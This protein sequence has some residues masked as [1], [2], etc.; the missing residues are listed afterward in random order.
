MEP[1]ELR[2]PER[3]A[4]EVTLGEVA[5]WVKTLNV[6]E[7]DETAAAAEVWAAGQVRAYREPDSAPALFLLDRF[8]GMF[9]EDQC[10]FLGEAFLLD[11][12]WA[13]DALRR[14]PG[15][16]AAA[17]AAREVDLQSRFYDRV[18]WATAL[19]PAARLD[20]CLIEAVLRRERNL[21][22]FRLVCE[23]LWRA[24]RLGND[25][26]RRYWSDV[27]AVMELADA[28][29]DWFWQVYEGMQLP[30][31]AVPTLAAVSPA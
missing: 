29:R 11:G 4:C 22:G 6:W 2:L 23:T 20:Q 19:P 28:D 24:V 17:V 9:I 26:A 3:T 7:R 1:S 31:A 5:L 8:G 16:D 10:G 18:E 30:V 15:D 13:A 25:H 12:S 14:Y 21:R 27:G